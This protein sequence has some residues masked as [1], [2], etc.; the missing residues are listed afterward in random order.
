M[1]K[2]QSEL[3]RN[4]IV[5]AADIAPKLAAHRVHNRKVVFTNGCFDILHFGHVYYL[6]AAKDHGD[7]LVVGL[8]ADASVRRL[9]GATRPINETFHRAFVLASL[10]AVDF[11]V[12]FEED[13]PLELIKTIQPDVLVKGADY[14][15]DQVVGAKEV[16][17]NGG[18]VELIPFIPGQSTTAIIQKA[19]DGKG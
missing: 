16:L 11:V 1:K 5:N 6:G 8:N 2:H 19:Q 17:A 10:Q 18:R 7:L 13:T 14:T 4:K 9:K 3:V 15:I 12:V